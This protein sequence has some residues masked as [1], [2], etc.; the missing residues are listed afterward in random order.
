MREFWASDFLLR[1][2]A[3]LSWVKNLRE[4]SLTARPRVKLPPVS[5]QVSY[6]AIIQIASYKQSQ[7]SMNVILNLKIYKNDLLL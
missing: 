2:D 5:Y 6:D 3:I 1:G 4:N 7:G